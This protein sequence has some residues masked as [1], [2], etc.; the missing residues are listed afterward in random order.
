MTRLLFSVSIMIVLALSQAI[1][2]EVVFQKSWDDAAGPAYDV[3]PEGRYGPQGFAVS[4]DTV[5]VLDNQNGSIKTYVGESL[6]QQVNVPRGSY[7]MQRTPEGFAVSD[8]NRVWLQDGQAL[9][10]IHR[11]EGPSAITGLEAE[12]GILQV[13]VN[14]A[15]HFFY[16]LQ[17]AE[18][19]L[20]DERTGSSLKAIKEGGTR[21]RLEAFGRTFTID[22]PVGDLASIQIV[23]SDKTQRVYVDIELFENHVPLKIRR[24]VRQYSPDGR[25]LNRIHL[26]AQSYAFIDN[27]LQVSPDGK[28]YHMFADETSLKI[29]EWDLDKAGTDVRAYPQSYYRFHGFIDAG[30]AEPETEQSEIEKDFSLNAVLPTVTSDEALETGDSYVRL[31]WSC[32]SANITNGTITDQYGYKVKTPTWVT[33]GSHQNM[34]YKWGGF[35][36]LNQFLNGLNSGKYAG[37]AYTSKSVGSP[38][39]VGVDCSGF[40]SRCWNLTSHYSTRMMDDGIT[41]TYESWEET[42]P[43]D[44]AHIVGHVR[45]VVHH[46][47]NGTITMVESAGYNWR[48]SYRAYSFSALSDYTPRYYINMQGTPGNLP[49]PE[50]TTVTGKS[51]IT[52]NWKMAQSDEIA[53]LRLYESG[54]GYDW[55]VS[56]ELDKSTTSYSF[57]GTDSCRFY[58]LVG[59]STDVNQST[60]IPSDIYAQYSTRN[61]KKILIVDGFDRTTAT[62]GSWPHM[63]HDFAARSGRLLFAMGYPFETA[64]NEAVAAGT[65]NLNDYWAVIWQLGDESTDDET[66][67]DGE[68]QKVK[69]YLS[70]GGK[71]FISGSEIA[72]DLDYSGQSSDRS[73]F[74]SYLKAA[75]REDDSNSY[76]VN[77]KSGSPFSGLNFSYDDGN[78]GIY[79][80][81]YPDV[82]DAVNGAKTALNYANG[83]PAAVYYEGTFGSGAESGKLFYMGFPFETIYEEDQQKAL[84]S[85]VLDFFDTTTSL[86]GSQSLPEKFRLLGN[87]PNPF[88]GQTVISFAAPTA[89]HMSLEVFNSL[90]QSI[91]RDNW[92]SQSG[93]GRYTLNAAS[94][95]SG[96]YFYR[97]NHGAYGAENGRFILIK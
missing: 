86:A 85:A 52:L 88:N 24:E 59:V 92:T 40:V 70:N 54:D 94:W 61:L 25:L 5:F 4:K 44:A 41:L 29:L 26:P 69:N 68:Q 27:D 37:D 79:K 93:T 77:G 39:A 89:G 49:Q 95:P 78:H 23:G 7:V 84:L 47:S 80:E 96:N 71:L 90:G 51:D 62:R 72:W 18:K 30:E 91:Y 50:L 10:E 67:D 48:V 46:N 6:R 35:Q 21:A 8:G 14:G 42:R 16:D 19:S 17:K 74:S 73:F 11:S 45:M 64:S 15:E 76:G 53:M 12:N 33:P 13:E 28:L 38:S 56:H 32:T 83:K 36:T 81:D 82:I 3:L 66:L 31:T 43:G 9:N 55:S 20:Q 58:K 2:Q 60:S 97:L 65:I 22:F 63:H 1:A 87:Y 75:Y 34:A 57:T